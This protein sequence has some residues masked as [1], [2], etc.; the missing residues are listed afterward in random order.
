MPVTFRARNL[1]P[2]LAVFVALQL[3]FLTGAFRIDDTNILA[4]AKQIA[5][6]PFDPYG[7]DFNWTGT[8]RPAFDILANPPLVPALI[9]GW[10]GI[11]GWSEVSLHALTLLFALLAIAAFYSIRGDDLGAALLASS[12]AFFIS[13]QTVMPDMLM[14]ALMLGAVAAAMRYRDD[15]R[16]APIAFACGFFAPIAKYNAVILVALLATIAFTARERRR[17]LAG[18]AISPLIGLSIWNLFTLWRYGA[19]HLLIVS[20]ER[21]YNLTHTFADLATEGKRMAAI[22]PLVSA[23]VL[24][25][26]VIVPLGW[27]LLLRRRYEWALAIVTGIVALFVARMMLDY[28]LSSAILFA[29]G[30]AAGVRAIAFA[31]GSRNPLVIVWVIAVLGFQAITLAVAVRYLLPVLPAVL[32]IIP[33][34]R[35]VTALIAVAVSLA[36]SLPVAIAERAAANCY[37]DFVARLPTHHFYFAGHWGFQHYAAAAGGTL[38]D[39]RRP[40]TLRPGDV[41][42]IA[43]HAFPSPG[44]FPFSSHGRLARVPCESRFPIHTISC[45]AAASYNV[46]EISGCTSSPIFLPFGFSRE[47]LEE[48]DVFVVQ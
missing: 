6:A 48:F 10:A 3:P 18:I 27:Q 34:V 13:S 22:D 2:L 32:L 23:V 16:L 47:P 29:I 39:V 12:P 14:L 43:S 28:P 31:V 36:V 38:I 41:V 15:G 8:A 30:V 20:E 11:F 25:G 9:A 19:M 40:L 45:Q 17:V 37:R 21:K 46:S 5:R 1:V 26:L 35:R 33:R 4:I 7:F 24:T 42:V 44:R